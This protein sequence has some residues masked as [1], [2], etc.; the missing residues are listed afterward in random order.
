MHKKLKLLQTDYCHHFLSII[1]FN[2]W[3][4]SSISFWVIFCTSLTIQ[5][6]WVF[7]GGLF[8]FCLLLLLL[9]EWVLVCIFMSGGERCEITVLPAKIT[10]LG[11]NEPLLSPLPTL[12]SVNGSVLTRQRLLNMKGWRS[13]EDRHL[14]ECEV[15]LTKSKSQHIKMSSYS[16]LFRAFVSLRDYT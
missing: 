6:E 15:V 3:L 16:R 11:N 5:D 7:F 12:C 13:T 1:H 9:I 2:G 14:V 10:L 8:P 4:K